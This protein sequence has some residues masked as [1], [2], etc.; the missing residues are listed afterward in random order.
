MTTI[1]ERKI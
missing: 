1:V